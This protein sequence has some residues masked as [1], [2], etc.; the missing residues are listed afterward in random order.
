MKMRD[1][2]LKLN[3][4]SRKNCLKP[5]QAPVLEASKC[6]VILKIMADHDLRQ[7][8]QVLLVVLQVRC[9]ILRDCSTIVPASYM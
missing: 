2:L 5:K 1:L 8:Q 6:D 7:L 9:A 3:L 4:D